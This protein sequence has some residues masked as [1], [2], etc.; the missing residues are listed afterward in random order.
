MMPMDEEGATQVQVN[1]GRPFPLFPLDGVVLLPHAMLRLFVFEPRYRQMM[2]DVLDGSGQVAMAVFQGDEWRESY[3]ES[4]P[5][6]PAVCVGQVAHHE[7]QA[8]GTYRVWLQG[9]CRARVL[10]EMEPEGE[11]L[12]RSV[13]LEPLEAGDRADDEEEED[14]ALVEERTRL[15]EL[16][17]TEPLSGVASVRRLVD[18]LDEQ[19]GGLDA[20]PTGV[21]LEVVALSVVG[22]LDE[23]MVMYA[24]LEE[25]DRVKRARIIEHE[26]VGLNRLLLRAERQWDP[27]APKGVS[28]N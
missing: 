25:G 24:L 17:R 6:K 20:L 8:D 1:F 19:A 3:H 16:M 14:T 15:L 23:P 7:R 27:E 21:L 22:S 2:E 11:R 10:E 28:W 13:V 18:Q 12:Y 4:P 5:I 9:V 26:L